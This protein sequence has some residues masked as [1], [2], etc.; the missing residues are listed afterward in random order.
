[1]AAIADFEQQDW[2]K[3]LVQDSVAQQATKKHMDPNVAF[4][5]Q[6]DFS[7]GTI[8]SANN[9]AVTHNT[10]KVVE[11]QDN[12]DKVSI[13]RTKTAGDTQSEVVV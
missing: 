10:N 4:P 3:Q 9:K 11:I 8:H 5:F 13:L 7:V 1:M 2:V 12:E 6:D